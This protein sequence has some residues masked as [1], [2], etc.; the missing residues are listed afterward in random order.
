MLDYRAALAHFPKIT[1]KRSKKLLDRFSNPANIWEAEIQ[2]LIMAGLEDEIANEFIIWKEANPVEKLMIRLEKEGIRAISIGEPDYPYLLS[3][4]SDPPQTIFVRGTLPPRGVPALAVVGTRRV[5]PYGRQI[6][7]TIVA[8]LARQD[9]VI[10]S[11]LALGIDGVAHET[12][13]KQGG[14]TLAVLGTGIDRGHVYPAY[15]QPLSEQII[16]RGGAII[17]EY[18]PG[19]LATQ[20]SFPARN[21]IIAGLSLGTLV[22]EAPASS[23]A[24]ITA[25]CALDYNREVMAVPHPLNSPVGEGCNNLIKAGAKLVACAN[26]VNEA[27]NLQTIVSAVSGRKPLPASQ[28]E[29][30]IF[31]CLKKEPRHIDFII[32]E[33]G[34]TS[35]VVN[36]SLV[37]MEMKGLIKNLGGMNFTIGL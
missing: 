36:G 25:R 16:E 24:L 32:K 30:K 10:V 20:Y 15:H 9:M 7:E 13:L 22:V 28:A 8:E 6:C 11:G 19:F 29:E 18:P 26:D 37:M 4:I 14:Q 1:F 2:D 27:L 35:S 5:S 31:Y 34:L 3:E 17:S 12:T 23:G 21:R 33:T